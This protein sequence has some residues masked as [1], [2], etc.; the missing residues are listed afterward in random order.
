MRKPNSRHSTRTSRP[1]LV[2]QV[3]FNAQAFHRSSSMYEENFLISQIDQDLLEI[4]I[5][6]KSDDIEAILSQL[7][8]I[9]PDSAALVF[10]RL[11]HLSEFTTEHDPVAGTQKD[12][13]L[14]TAPVLVWTRY[15][16]PEVTLN[17]A[18][19][20][21][22]IEGLKKFILADGVDVFGLSR[23]LSPFEMPMD[24]TDTRQWLQTMVQRSLRAD[25]AEPEP[26]R[27]PEGLS[28]LA[29][30]RHMVL[31]ASAH[32][33][34]PI[35]RWMPPQSESRDQCLQDWRSHA[36]SLFT[37]LFPGC[38]IEV[39]MPDTFF[40]SESASR[41]HLR[42]IGIRASVDWLKSALNLEPGELRANIM[43][44][45]DEMTQEFRVGYSRKTESEVIFGSI[46]PKSFETLPEDDPDDAAELDQLVNVLKTAGIQDIR[47]LSGIAPMEYCSDCGAPMFPNRDAEIVHAEMPDEAFDMPQH[48]H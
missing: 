31:L 36:H 20:N 23:L 35:F 21:S 29:D 33:G 38:Q 12:F 41:E 1:K 39:D 15:A 30:S 10:E 47:I 44:F 7:T 34:K 6:K 37:A 19:Q 13:L 48:F 24:F 4:M 11:Q 32:H 43:R 25:S 40:T 26:G 18:T 22:L 16:I 28:L 9:S 42:P 17:A 45:G 3:I 8:E 46:W 14:I 27:F 5:K 2:R